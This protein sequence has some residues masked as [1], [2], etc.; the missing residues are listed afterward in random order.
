LRAS[1]PGTGRRLARLCRYLAVAGIVLAAARP[2]V[3]VEPAGR[4]RVLELVVD[5]SG[6]TLADDIAPTRLQAVERAALRLLDQVPAGL[7]VGLVSFSTEAETLV[8]PTTDRDLVRRRIEGLQAYGGT[9]IG[10]AL[11][12]ALD[13]VRASTP[14][15]PAAV[16]LFSDGANSSG[17]DPEVPAATAADRRIPV[18]TVAVGTPQGLLTQPNPS[19]GMRYQPVPPD[20]FQLSRIAAVTRGRAV[21]ARS[22]AELQAGVD[23]LLRTAGLLGERRDMTLLLAAAAL[24]L[25]AVA[26][27]LRPVRSPAAGAVRR[28]APS[29]ALLLV[30]GVTAAAWTGW[31][32]TV[33]PPVA[34]VDIP[35]HAQQ[36]PPPTRPPPR[37][38][39]PAGVAVDAAT[40]ADR[41]T[42]RLAAD[43]LDRHGEL[44][45]HRPAEL[46]R[47][48][49][50]RASLDLTACE[51]CKTGSLS[52]R[53][54]YAQPGGG[55]C[56]VTLNTAVIRRQ[57]GRA[58]VPASELTALAM[59]HEQEGCLRHN[60]STLAPFTAERRL[61]RKLGRP[62]LFDLLYAQVTG[63]AQDWRTVHQAIALLRGQGEL[64]LQ[65]GKHVGP[66]DIEVCRSCLKVNLAE[67]QPVD[68]V[69]GLVECPIYLDMAHVEATAR[70]WTLPLT[71]VAASILIHE[72]EHCIRQPDDREIGPLAA[73]RRLA[74]KLGDARLLEFVAGY[75]DQLDPTGHWKG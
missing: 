51:F 29:A 38:V 8:R 67:A 27:L 49:S 59:L 24:L 28:W 31:Q 32:P 26:V 39:L 75:S 72:Q 16:L 44:A 70:D 33:P 7:R 74:R 34:A 56:V 58:R 69:D 15:A 42:V 65:R 12:Q 71:K 14:A 18:L 22:A 10:A 36:T 64:A 48:L 52:K 61:A 47:R 62:R 17:P 53:V 55:E 20:P 23:S 5:V 63:G 2:T 57:A 4:A 35:V 3:E 40:A 46:G 1:R 66:L 25:L 11:Q 43:L 9:A 73:E 13:D 30:A 6:S 50:E 68:E 21:E 37:P 45:S 60:G 19:G 41:K 54:R